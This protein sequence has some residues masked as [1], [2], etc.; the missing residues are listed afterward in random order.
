MGHWLLDFDK[1]LN[2]YQVPFVVSIDVV[3]PLGQ[4]VKLSYADRAAGSR[5]FM[6]SVTSFVLKARTHT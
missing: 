1:Y 6:K 5:S 3:L 4:V 2:T